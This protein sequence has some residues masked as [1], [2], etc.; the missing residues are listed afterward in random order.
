MTI[1][2]ILSKTG[3]ILWDNPIPLLVFDY[4]E[5]HSGLKKEDAVKMKR[6]DSLLIDSFRHIYGQYLG[7]CTYA[8]LFD[9]PNYCYNVYDIVRVPCYSSK[10]YPESIS[11][12]IERCLEIHRDQSLIKDHLKRIT[13][14]KYGVKIN[15]SL[16][17]NFVQQRFNIVKSTY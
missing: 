14:S 5:K 11:I 12:D 9:I 1:T 15:D 10:F 16:K 6:H 8:Y 2:L 3:A 17:P 4:I 7:S 13:I